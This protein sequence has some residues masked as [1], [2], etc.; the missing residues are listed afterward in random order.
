[1]LIKWIQ[2]IRVVK[3]TVVVPYFRIPVYRYPP[4]IPIQYIHGA[5]RVSL[6]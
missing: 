5:E 1:M 6:Y 3:L 2:P 4:Y